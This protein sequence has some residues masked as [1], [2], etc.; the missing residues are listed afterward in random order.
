MMNGK[1]QEMIF[2]EFI[3][4]RPS[5]LSII[6]YATCIRCYTEVHTGL[7]NQTFERVR[8]PT[9][10]LATR[11]K[12]GRHALRLSKRRTSKANTGTPGWAIQAPD[13]WAQARSSAPRWERT[14]CGSGTQSF[15]EW[16]DYSDAARKGG[17]R[18]TTRTAAVLP[19]CTTLAG[20]TCTSYSTLS[21]VPSPMG[22]PI[23]VNR[24][25]VCRPDMALDTNLLV[26]RGP[27]GIQS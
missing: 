21:S 8:L 4:L 2:N 26:P 15:D 14:R 10:L 18:R 20:V 22:P 11:Q 24:S 27:R 1:W 7:S 23:K 6:L 9:A 16:R 13:G 17:R 25:P 19:T 3:R 12:L 5:L